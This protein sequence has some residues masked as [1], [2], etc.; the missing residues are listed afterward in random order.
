MINAINQGFASLKKGGEAA[1]L[2]LTPG[3]YTFD[4]NEHIIFKGAIVRGIVGR[5]LWETWYQARGLLEAGELNLDPL[6]TH[7]FSMRDFEQAYEVFMSG[8]SGKIMFTP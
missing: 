8:A 7:E 3:P 6:V 1:L 2:G 4:L 5:R